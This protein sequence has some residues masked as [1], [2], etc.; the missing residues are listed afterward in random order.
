MTNIFDFPGAD[1]A[2]AARQEHGEF[3]FEDDFLGAG[4]TQIP[5]IVLRMP[6]LSAD[7]K[8]VYAGLLS[9]AWRDRQCYPGHRRLAEDLGLSRHTIM[10]RINEL[11]SIGLLAVTHRKHE[12]KTNL[13]VFKSLNRFLGV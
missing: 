4:F 7:A 8:L 10:R 9:Y 1:K 12:G 5:N 11:E 13:Y 3:A 6:G 2:K